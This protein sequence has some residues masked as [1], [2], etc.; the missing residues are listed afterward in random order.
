MNH[1]K[2]ILSSLDNIHPKMLPYVLQ[3]CC[4][5]ESYVSKSVVDETEQAL[6]VAGGH[7]VKDEKVNRAR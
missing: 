2:K 7:L 3:L 4:R 6:Q 1:A 5:I